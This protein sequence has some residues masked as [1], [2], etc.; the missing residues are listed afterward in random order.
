MTGTQPPGS[1]RCRV[2]VGGLG[3]PG[4]RDL[5][6]G[7]QFVRYAEQ[8]A[9]S[10]GVVLEDLSCAAPLVLHRLLELDPAR[11]VLVGAV[12]RGT[13]GPGSVRRYR[14]D[15]ATPHPAKVHAG[16][17][18]SVEGMVDLD[19]TLSVVRHWGGLPADTVVVEV[20][21]ADT[22][23]GPGFSE[24]VGVALDRILEIVRE[25]VGGAEVAG[26]EVRDDAAPAPRPGRR[27]PTLVELTE[28]AQAHREVSRAVNRLRE[29][30]PAA[31]RVAGLEVVADLRPFG[32][33]LEARASWYDL[34]DLDDGWIG[35][36]IGD[37]AEQ[38]LDAA[39]V[40]SHLRAATRAH[41]ATMGRAPVRVVEGVDRVVAGTGLGRGASLLYAAVDGTTGE[42]RMANAGHPPPLLRSGPGR[43]E[44]LGAGRAGTLGSPGTGPGPSVP[45]VRLRLDAGS[46]LLLFSD[47]LAAPPRAGP[48]SGIE[49]LRS[50][51]AGEAPDLE[52]LCQQVMTACLTGAR[53]AGD[54]ALVAVARRR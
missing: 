43:I 48:Q 35:V 38:G 25:E 42:A 7:R 5:D 32:R 33:G 52:S 9:W 30:P 51:A 23:F 14:L 29:V 8:F 41:A 19:H 40:A 37:V 49:R 10:P 45:E 27:P 28:R 4:L 17:A 47:G 24:E 12:A 16:L 53:R 44:T 36:A 6:A 2:L 20:E 15:R 50:A 22:S 54:A 3:L 39:V 34:I 26:A 46:A 11:V 13:A 18:G 21:P 31:P 1:T